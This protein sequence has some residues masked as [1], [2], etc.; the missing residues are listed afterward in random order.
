LSI[1]SE[2]LRR[3]Y[4]LPIRRK[5]ALSYPLPRNMALD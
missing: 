2:T 4:C 5:S 3:A 1:L